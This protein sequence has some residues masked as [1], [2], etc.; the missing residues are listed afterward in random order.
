[1]K[2]YKYSG[3]GNDFVFFNALDSKI[4]LTAKQIQ[5]ICNRRSG[6][7]ADG[8]VVI[9]VSKKCDYF[10][11]IFNADGSNPAMCGNASRCGL[12]FAKN[13][14][15]L[16]KPTYSF[17]TLNGV[18]YGNLIAENEAKV[19]MTELYDVDAINLSDFSHKNTLYLNTGVP[20]AVIEVTS[21]A[22][23]NIDAMG[24]VIRSD[25]RFSEGTNVDFFE[26]VN[27]KNQEI[28]IRVYERGVEAETLCCGT[29]IMATAVACHRFYGWTG[30]IKVHA[31]GGELVA[32]VDDELAKLYFQG[33]VQLVYEGELNL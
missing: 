33:P 14:L 11:N 28:S 10:L 22:D 26:V 30:E 3:T 24:H 1:M 17:E 13:I 31:A 15:K 21:V 7:G 19:Q 16:D 6:V 29:G 4:D 32:L 12:H 23:V 9:G 2:F 27:P 8:V 25:Q 5:Y 20:H 18:Y